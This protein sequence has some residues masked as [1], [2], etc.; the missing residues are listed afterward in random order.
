MRRLPA[1]ATVVLVSACTLRSGAPAL[2]PQ[3]PLQAAVSRFAADGVLYVA[4]ELGN[5]I[6]VYQL[7][8][9]ARWRKITKGI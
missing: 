3:A 9:N 2:P 4:N 8:S 1:L 5:S 7:A 6:Y